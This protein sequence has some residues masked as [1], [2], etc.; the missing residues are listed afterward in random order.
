MPRILPIRPTATVNSLWRT[1]AVNEKLAAFRTKNGGKPPN[2]LYILI[3]DI[4][5]TV[6]QQHGGWTEVSSREGE[7]TE[8][9]V[10][11]PR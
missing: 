1:E 2:I 11:L 7:L 9:L 3:D 5:E 10:T 8:F 4:D 6:V